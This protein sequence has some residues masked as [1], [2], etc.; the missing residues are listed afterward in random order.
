MSVLRGKTA[1]SVNTILTFGHQTSTANDGSTE[2]QVSVITANG[3]TGN[4][5]YKF[6]KVTETL[7]KGSA[8]FIGI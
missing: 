6:R 4:G 3:L 2:N 5:H 8:G 7:P 1:L